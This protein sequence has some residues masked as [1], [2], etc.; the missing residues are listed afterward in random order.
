MTPAPLVELRA[1]YA[2]PSVPGDYQRVAALLGQLHRL[3]DRERASEALTAFRQK[4]GMHFRDKVCELLDEL[5]PF[6]R[7][8]AD[9]GR[10]WAE[11]ALEQIERTG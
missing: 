1:L 6:R 3:G 11:R 5:V 4:R 8:T 2:R 7:A 9:F 10:R